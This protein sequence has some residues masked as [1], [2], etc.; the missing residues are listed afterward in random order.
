[1]KLSDGSTVGYIPDLLASVLAPM[2]D[3]SE[4]V[5]VSGTISGVPRPASEGIWVPGD[6]IEIP[7]EYVLYGVKK[8][9]SNIRQRL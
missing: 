3:S 1:M 5:H 4:M 8:D 7:C 9:H 2:L 6:G